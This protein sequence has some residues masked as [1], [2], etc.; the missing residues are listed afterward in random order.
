MSYL[1]D[2]TTRFWVELVARS[3]GPLALRFI[4]QPVTASLLAIRDGYKD[5]CDGR[6]P[7][8]WTIL[9]NP[10]RRSDRI[11]EGLIAV[12]HVLF[13]GIA[14]EAIHRVV[15]LKSFRP[16]EM[17]DIA[18]AAACRLVET[19]GHRRHVESDDVETG[20]RLTQSDAVDLGPISGVA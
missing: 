4:I 1:H 20:V 10:D 11:Y 19:G 16:F 13:L 7:Y 14:L 3:S 8:F 6:T 9:H 17:I 2:V 15:V 12:S 5:A 18:P